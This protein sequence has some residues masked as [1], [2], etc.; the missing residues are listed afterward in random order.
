MHKRCR[1]LADTDILVFQ[2][3]YLTIFFLERLVGARICYCNILLCFFTRQ[4]EEITDTPANPA[5][6]TPEMV[7]AMFPPVKNRTLQ[8]EEK[9]CV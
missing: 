2:S 3:F 9:R 6:L 1:F 8:Q 4:D 7:F 5:V